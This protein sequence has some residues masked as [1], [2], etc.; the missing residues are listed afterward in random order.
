M[1]RFKIFKVFCFVLSVA[2]ALYY[3]VKKIMQYEFSPAQ[4]FEFKVTAYD[5][6][7]PA[8]GHF[9]ALTVHPTNFKRGNSDCRYAV[10]QVDQ[11]G[12]A[13]VQEVIGKPDGRACVKLTKYSKRF[14]FNRFYINEEL[15]QAADKIFQEAANSKRCALRVN[16]YSDGASAVEDLLINGVSIR[17]LAA[18]KC[19]A[20]K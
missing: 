3:P 17:K 18:E 15:A 20:Q 13:K 11:D 12:F 10:L 5:P 14:P 2:A 16:V 8:R 7:D 6:Y 9:L 1:N 4:V 19:N